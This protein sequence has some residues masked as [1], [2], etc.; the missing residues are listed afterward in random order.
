MKTRTLGME[1]GGPMKKLD[2][3]SSAF[4]LC[5]DIALLHSEGHRKYLRN[6]AET[7]LCL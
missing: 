5:E 4:H 1:S 3:G 6:R 2:R 7:G